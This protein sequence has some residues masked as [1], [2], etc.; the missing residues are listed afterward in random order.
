MWFFLDI[1]GQ[2][3]SINALCAALEFQGHD[4]VLLNSLTE[5]YR[6]NLPKTIF[7]GISFSSPQL[8]DVFKQVESLPTSLRKKIIL[9][10]GGPHPCGDIRGTLQY[11]DA[12]CIGDGEET[13]IDVAKTCSL[14]VPGLVIKDSEKYR[15]T[16][17]RKCVDLN[18]FP[19]FPSFRFGPIEITRG[20]PFACNFCQTSRIFGKKIRHRSIENICYFVEKM[21][22]LDKRDIRFIT[23]NA[24]SYGSRDGKKINI[25][26]IQ[27]L[28]ENVRSVVGSSG[29]IFFGS[30]PSEVRPEH[31]TEDTV[32]LVLE[33][34]DNKRL[35]I[36]AQS[37]SQ[38]ILDLCN[39]GH[40][41][42]N[43]YLAVE[44]CVKHGL[45]P[46]VDF[47]FGLPGEEEED[48]NKSIKVME[49]LVNM[50]ARIHAHTFI[51]LPGTPFARFPPRE[52]HPKYK[53]F[54]EKMTG[55]GL[56]YGDWK[57]QE[58]LGKRIYNY[59]KRTCKTIG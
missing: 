31:V 34:C 21:I 29:R 44:I 3:Y 2:K 42:D 54:C 52:V 7:L 28:L 37:G 46:E 5:L 11:F 10:A 14:D 24:F 15:F 12:V 36:S 51:P 33:Y 22:E 45:I 50:G 32:S 8:W 41:V 30:F 17:K 56:V 13:V 40:T 38:R 57:K 47:I 20:C 9:V 59:L 53:E 26:T 48:I 43:V 6:K 19:P 49:D 55:K 4:F 27:K 18:R 1:P 35:I 58:E 25:N 16:G 23:P 39:R